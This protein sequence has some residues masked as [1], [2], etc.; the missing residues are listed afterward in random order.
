MEDTKKGLET[1]YAG[2]FIN[3]LVFFGG[4]GIEVS[5]IFVSLSRVLFILSNM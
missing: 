4:S 3:F 1:P 2:Y 5:D